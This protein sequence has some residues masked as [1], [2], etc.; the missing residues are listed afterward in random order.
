MAQLNDNTT[1]IQEIIALITE[2]A[3][4]R[5]IA[6]IDRT[7][8]TGAA[9]TTDT[10][11]IKYSDNTTSTF[12]VYNGANGAKGDKGDKGATPVRGTDYWTTADKAEIKAYVD[13]AILNGS[14]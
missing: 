3:A 2:K 13:D 8:G 1:K 9:G 4:G 14:W 5:S 11:T 12:T 10:Y 7:S 6:S